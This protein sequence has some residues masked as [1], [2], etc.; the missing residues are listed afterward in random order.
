MPRQ[1][2]IAGVAIAL[3]GCAAL[4]PPRSSAADCPTGQ[5]V[6]RPTVVTA[7]DSAFTIIGIVRNA[8]TLEGVRG[9]TI[10][11]AGDAGGERSVSSDAEGLFRLELS[12][13]AA[14]PTRLSVAARDFDAHL[15]AI[16]MSE[17]AGLHV[18]I[19]MTSTRSCLSR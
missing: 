1:L 7:T 10:S 6:R 12:R 4:R 18:E 14:L 15:H 3:V 19:F 2:V 5:P 8:A 9:A 11:V 17:N 13:G 16:G